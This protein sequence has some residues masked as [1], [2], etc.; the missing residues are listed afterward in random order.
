MSLQ[1]TQNSLVH[2]CSYFIQTE[3]WSDELNFTSSSCSFLASF[4]PLG[5]TLYLWSYSFTFSLPD[6]RL[7]R[8]FC[9]SIASLF[10]LSERN[11][12][13]KQNSWEK[14][15]LFVFARDCIQLNG[16]QHLYFA[17][18]IQKEVLWLNYLR[19]HQSSF[20]LINH[21]KSLNKLP[22]EAR[23]VFSLTLVDILSKV[24]PFV[25]ANRV[26]VP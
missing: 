26:E 14:K 19:L 16:R 20:A 6:V 9:F 4:F 7:D 13:S 11:L 23:N 21:K 1:H 15:D 10:L 2:L 25:T 18:L 12:R 3:L 22:S 5:R 24:D 17:P 8:T